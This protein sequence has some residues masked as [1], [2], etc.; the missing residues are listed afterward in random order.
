MKKDKLLFV[1]PAYNE[2]MNIEKVLKEI[3]EGVDVDLMQKKETKS[4]APQ[5]VSK[6]SI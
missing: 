4:D 3:K 5:G 2:S 6:S 1:I